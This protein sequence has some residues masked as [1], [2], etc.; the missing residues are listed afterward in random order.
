MKFFQNKTNQPEKTHKKH[1]TNKKQT[2]TPKQQQ[3]KPSTKWYHK[4]LKK[5]P[6]T[7]SIKVIESYEMFV[8]VLIKKCLAKGV[9]RFF[10]VLVLLRKA[11]HGSELQVLWK[12]AIK[13]GYGVS[14]Y[15]YPLPNCSFVLV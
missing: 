9:R 3:K 12:V 15:Q 13:G 5:N 4:L 14:K 10:I 6:K 7:K 1:K 11:V 2:Q 8:Q